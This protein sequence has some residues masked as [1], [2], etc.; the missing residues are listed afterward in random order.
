MV[1]K[2]R[3]EPVELK[4]LRCLNTRMDLSVKEKQYYINLE[5]GYEGERIFDD[6]LKNLSNEWIILNDLLFESNHTIF[7]IDS[8]L[9]SPKTIYLFEVKNYEG[10]FYINAEKWYTLSGNEIKNPLLQLTRSESLLRQLLQDLGLNF[11]IEAYIIFINPEFTL[12]QA[13]LNL[14]I[15]FPSQLNRFMKK[16]NMSSSK[17]NGKHAKLAEQL[18]SA[19]LDESPYSRLPAYDYDQLQKG[20]TC[21]LCNSFMTREKKLVCKE[22]GCKENIESAVMRSVEQYKLLFP[23][24]K[25]TTNA[26]HEWCGV[27]ESKLTIRKILTKN[28]NLLGHGKFSYYVHSQENHL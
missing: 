17:L 2:P 6:L 16:L 4:I 20:M 3:F 14:P 12:F 7:Q 19:H 24:R 11:S 15:I 8:L 23:V 26:I 5:K 1:I 18:V 22:C 9:I 21:R 25:I 27:I 28:Y 13:P 10:D